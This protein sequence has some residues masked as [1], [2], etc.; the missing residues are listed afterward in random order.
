[1]CKSS[2][3]IQKSEYR[4]KKPLRKMG[5]CNKSKLGLHH[6]SSFSIF[7]T[8]FGWKFAANSSKFRKL[9][10]QSE[11]V[12]I[13]KIKGKKRTEN[14]DLMWKLNKIAIQRHSEITPPVVIN[15][16]PPSF[17]SVVVLVSSYFRPNFAYFASLSNSGKKFFIEILRKSK[18]FLQIFMKSTLKI[19]FQ[20]F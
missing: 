1:M 4:A 2:E 20:I 13:S 18:F 7:S 19:K 10:F 5:N 3:S 6:F 16:T 17:R 14:S 15:T 12:Q 11:N 9:N 8:N